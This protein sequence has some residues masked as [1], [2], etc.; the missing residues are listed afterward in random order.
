MFFTAFL[1]SKIGLPGWSGSVC[2]HAGRLGLRSQIQIRPTAAGEVTA[3]AWL[4]PDGGDLRHSVRE[5]D[6][7]VVARP[8]GTLTQAECAEAALAPRGLGRS[9]TALVTL[10]LDTAAGRL[11][12]AVP[13][14]TPEQVF[15]TRTAAGFVVADDLRLFP[16]LT[17]CR[18]DPA[19]VFALM[20]FG[21][22]PA[23]RSLFA[24]VHRIAGGQVLSLQARASSESSE[25]LSSAPD[26]VIG[27]SDG[28]SRRLE[29]LAA[30]LDATLAAVPP[31]AALFFSGGVDS[32]LLASRLARLG[33]RDV[34]LC[35]YSFGDDDGEGALAR[36]MAGQLGLP[37]VQVQHS[38]ARVAEMLQRLGLDYSYP[39]GDLSTIPTNILVHGAAAA[40][41]PRA[42]VVEGTGADGVFGLASRY[43]FWR[44]LSALPTPLRGIVAGSARR[45]RSWRYNSGVARLSIFVGKTVRMPL[46]LAVIAQNDLDGIAYHMPRHVRDSL[47]A[48]MHA[49]VHG[50]MPDASGEAEVSLTDVTFVCA[51]TMAPKSFDPLRRLGHRAI[52]PYL[53]PSIAYR[54]MRWPPQAKAAHGIGKAAIKALLES[55]F[56]RTSIYRPKSGFT[57]PYAQLFASAPMQ[58]LAR[59]VALSRGNP[60]RD[61]CDAEWV[62]QALDA[63]RHR[64]LGPSVYDFLWTFIFASAWLAFA[65]D[66]ARGVRSS[67]PATQE[68]T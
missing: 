31:D 55:D 56:E 4:S 14:T 50:L 22:I 41:A 68:I 45:M 10:R 63:A 21:T 36:R 32:A 43:P 25:A 40:L 9:Q 52:Y 1:G 35:N 42:T 38:P 48:Q 7:T 13:A 62:T 5:V 11:S 44:R 46:P 6:G 26:E 12:I 20:Q 53:H 18:P 37:F 33:R 47:A 17:S 23:P 60:L 8:G 39:F 58:D 61:Y 54:G 64:Q 30:T 24:G 67:T 19:A 49:M 29:W 66:A 27:A 3:V 65:G 28:E 2:R 51:G 59:G 15:W 57:P 34:W 16:L